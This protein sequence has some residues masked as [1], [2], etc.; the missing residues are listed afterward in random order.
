MF[1]DAIE[2]FQFAWYV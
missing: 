2:G 1:E